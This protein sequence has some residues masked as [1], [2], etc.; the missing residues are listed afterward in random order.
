MTVPR[1]IPRALR[2]PPGRM[3]SLWPIGAS[4]PGR[5]RLDRF[6]HDEGDERDPGPPRF[7]ADRRAAGSGPARWAGPRR[8]TVSA[9]RRHYEQAVEALS[10][11]DPAWLGGLISRR[12][13]LSSWQQVLTRERDDVKVVVD[14]TK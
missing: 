9:A 1:S 4:A 7:G 11:A 10:Q 12:V 8:G 6:G 3:D 14:L 13:P 2:R 5:T